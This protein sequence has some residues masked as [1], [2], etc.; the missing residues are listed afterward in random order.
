MPTSINITRRIRKRKLSSGGVVEQVRWVVNYREPR[1]GR[2]RQL[3]FERQKDAQMKGNDIIAQVA[4]GT[5]ATAQSELVTVAEV[6]RRWVGSRETYVERNTLVGYGFG[7]A[8]IIGPLLI[9]T[10]LQRSEFTTTGNVPPGTRLIPLLGEVR[11]VDLTTSHIREWHKTISVEVG[12]YSANRAKMILNAALALAAE[13]MNIRPPSMPGK[14]GPARQRMKKVILTPEQVRLLLQSAREDRERGV[15]VAFPFLTGTRPSEQLGLLWEDIDFDANI[16]RIC[17]MQER[18][19]SLTCLTKTAAGTREIPMGAS[20]RS[21]LM[22]WRL[23]CPRRLGELHRVFPGPGRP[24]PWPLPRIGGGGPPHLLEFPP[25]ALG[26]GAQAPRS[27]HG[28][29]SQR[30]ACIHID[31]AGS[32]YRSGPRGEAGGPLQCRRHSRAL[33]SGRPRR[34]ERGRSARAGV[35]SLG[36][37]RAAPRN[38][39]ASRRY[40]GGSPV[41]GRRYSEVFC[42][43]L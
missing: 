40:L 1:T 21:L 29:P 10:P 8:N 27:A 25:A 42:Q 36:D 34:R 13:D 6:T 24:Q 23:A 31:A 5:Y 32:G 17:R 41:A 43:P 22:E 28:D 3:F 16:I 11:V 4:T 26:P 35:H 30:T 39:D 33:H 18:D 12:R 15:Y 7:V 14:L 20:L 2:R 37:R 9:G 19:G 38:P